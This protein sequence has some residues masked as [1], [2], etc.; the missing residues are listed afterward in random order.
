MRCC[1]QFCRTSPNLLILCI[2]ILCFGCCAV[3]QA[4]PQSPAQ[5]PSSRP[6]KVEVPRETETGEAGKDEEK[7]EQQKSEAEQESPAAVQAQP[8]NPAAMPEYPTEI[9]ATVKAVKPFP[10]EKV[11][12]N[13][14]VP[15]NSVF[16][17]V[18][19]TIHKARPVAGN[20]DVVVEPGAEVA[21]ITRDPITQKWVKKKLTGLVRLQGD[22][23][24]QLRFLSNTRLVTKKSETEHSK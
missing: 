13:E 14:D 21:L 6:P 20:H 4:A 24:S 10:I 22:T 19:L 23:R 3:A 2:A 11:H 9:V 12:L 16:L 8:A 7:E 17:E 5:N 15:S 1:T 18:R